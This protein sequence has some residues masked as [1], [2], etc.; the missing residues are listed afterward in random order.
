M[1]QCESCATRLGI[2]FECQQ[3]K[4]ILCQACKGKDAFCRMSPK[5]KANCPGMFVPA[6]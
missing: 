4:K 6:H 2:P 5:G 3:C 1:R